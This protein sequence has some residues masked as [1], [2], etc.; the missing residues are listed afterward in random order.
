MDM[1]A[2]KREDN[3]FETKQGADEWITMVESEKGTNRDKEIYPYLKAWIS[4]IRPRFVADIG[5]GQ[6]VCSEH[7][8]TVDVNYIGIEPST[9]LVERA[10]QLY[11]RA[12]IHF[13]IGDAYKLPLSAESMDACF[14]VTTWFHLADIETA[15]KELARVL[16]P[17]GHFLIITA[18]PNAYDIWESFF[19]NVKRS[20]GMFIG[21]NKILLNPGDKPENY[22][23]A[24]VTNNTF[25][26]HSLN[27][28]VESLK[29]FNLEIE[30]IEEF[31]ILPITQGRPIF[32]KI[33][34]QKM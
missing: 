19:T 2:K 14:S 9:F 31:G 22:K 12:N 30:S 16:K 18:N 33:I 8:G 27:D 24:Q 6:G 21:V 29:R 7:L 15:S 23:Y 13:V 28:I 1:L 34:G 26:T 25:Y 10:K 4:E 17:R 5:A 11:S 20:E 32:T 3:P